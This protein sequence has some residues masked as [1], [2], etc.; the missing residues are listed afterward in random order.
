[1]AAIIGRKP[2]AIWPSRYDDGGQPKRGLYKGSRENG[3]D[4]LARSVGRAR[5]GRNGNV[6]GN[7]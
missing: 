5:T 1:M 3:R 6:R 4:Y 7:A 2:Q